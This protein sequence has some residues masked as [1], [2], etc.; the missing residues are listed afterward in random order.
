MAGDFPVGTSPRAP[1]PPSDGH[2]A[3]RVMATVELG[4]IPRWEL[5]A[6]SS[7]LVTSD[8]FGYEVTHIDAPHAVRP[9]RKLSSADR[10]VGSHAARGWSQTDGLSVVRLRVPMDE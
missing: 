2:G 4:G 6:I 10:R 3:R 8:S 7:G 9:G 5:N 1:H